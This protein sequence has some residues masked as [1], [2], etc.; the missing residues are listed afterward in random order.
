MANVGRRPKFDVPIKER[1][2]ARTDEG[3]EARM[4]AYSMELAERQIRDGTV[5]ANVLVHYL[6]QG[7]IEGQL[8][9]EILKKKRD[10]LEAQK[11]SLESAQRV[12]EMYLKAM[13]AFKSYSGDQERAEE[14]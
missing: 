6:K 8:Q 1:P 13:S 14:T 3:Q 9:K 11:K 12:E 10:L 2:P 7:S 5:S 4:Y